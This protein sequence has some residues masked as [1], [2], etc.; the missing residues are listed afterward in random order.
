MKI[1]NNRNRPLGPGGAFKTGQ[2]CP[3]SGNWRDQYGQVIQ[4]D[5]HDTF[6]PC[7][8]RKGECA[9][10]TLMTEAAATA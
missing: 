2:R 3:T 9:Y 1:N 6:P 7:I 5:R 4:I 10:R 8:G